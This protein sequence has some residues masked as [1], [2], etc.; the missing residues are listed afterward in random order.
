MYFS[1]TD[2]IS[3]RWNQVLTK[4]KQRNGYDSRGLFLISITSSFLNFESNLFRVSIWYLDYSITHFYL[5]FTHARSCISY[6]CMIVFVGRLLQNSFVSRNSYQ[7]LS[8]WIMETPS[9]FHKVAAAR[10]QVARSSKKVY[11]W[12]SRTKMI[13]G[14]CLHYIQ[15]GN[16]CIAA[17]NAKYHA[18]FNTSALLKLTLYA[19]RYTMT[20]FRCER[21]IA[22][23]V[24]SLL[25][26][27][28][29]MSLCICNF[30]MYDGRTTT[31]KRSHPLE[32][33]IIITSSQFCTVRTREH[34]H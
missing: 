16:A 7:Q 30:A 8:M 19:I 33:V 28:D 26:S 18:S 21:D 23:K 5:L 31:P 13:S 1:T 29:P 27:D 15:C 32:E 17:T 10:I 3:L 25:A 11:R 24:L 20:N 12:K 14:K 2:E 6:V 9:S 34:T 4:F 22:L